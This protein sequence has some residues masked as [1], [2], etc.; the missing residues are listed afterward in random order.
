MTSTS[1]PSATTQFHQPTSFSI[2]DFMNKLMGRDSKTLSLLPLPPDEALK[3][4]L[5]LQRIADI[6]V[7]DATRDKK[8]Q[9]VATLEFSLKPET[10]RGQVGI[11]VPNNSAVAYETTKT[12]HDVNQLSKV[13]AYCIDK[14][15][16]HCDDGC[17]F[18]SKLREYLCT[19]WV[20]DPLVCVV[21]MGDTVLRKAS[22]AMHLA[23]LVAFVTGTSVAAPRVATILTGKGAPVMQLVP[24]LSPLGQSIGNTKSAAFCRAQ[25]EAAAV[26]YDFFDVFPQ[27][28]KTAT[29]VSTTEL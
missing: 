25:I 16:G 1:S 7:L 4:R 29:A 9:L 23:R 13:L 6:V 28:T 18:C 8:K 2:R 10:P 22:L 14:P 12:F 27:A 3:R 24:Q 17:A 15:T 26:L 20:R 11:F 19:H 21:S 5:E